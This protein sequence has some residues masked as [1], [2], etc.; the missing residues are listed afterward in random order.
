[1]LTYPTQ[2]L[3]LHTE[4]LE[5]RKRPETGEG[6]VKLGLL[7]EPHSGGGPAE[8]H[9]GGDAAAAMDGLPVEVRGSNGAFYK[10]TPFTDAEVKPG[11]NRN[12][13]V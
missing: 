9:S 11:T 6:P 10:V 12:T 4:T 1:M 13:V 8:R 3:S 5:I 2:P 7:A